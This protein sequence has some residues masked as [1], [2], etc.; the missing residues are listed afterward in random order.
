MQEDDLPE[1]LLSAPWMSV[2]GRSGGGAGG[3]TPSVPPKMLGQL[4]IYSPADVFDVFKMDAISDCLSAFVV[5]PE[6]SAIREQMLEDCGIDAEL[7]LRYEAS[8]SPTPR[9]NLLDVV[10]D[11]QQ[12]VDFSK[13]PGLFI[14]SV[15]R[16]MEIVLNDR[17]IA[18]GTDH[19]PIDLGCLHSRPPTM[20]HCDHLC[21]L[22]PPSQHLPRRFLR[23]RRWKPWICLTRG[24]SPPQPASTPRRSTR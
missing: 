23:R 8:L 9:G 14:D 4:P 21:P 20:S 7:F 13:A 16:K 6:H 19:P 17:G 24:R 11:L 10:D 12:G 2:G 18:A 15:Q 5:H 22:P 3:G 1:W